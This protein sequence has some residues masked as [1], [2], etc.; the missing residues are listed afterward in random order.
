MSRFT[1]FED[2]RIPV[3][4]PPAGPICAAGLRKVSPGD[5]SKRVPQKE[6]AEQ[7]IIVPGIRGPIF[8]NHAK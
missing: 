2:R 3:K 5:D 7:F 6:Q 8:F 1:P 4:L